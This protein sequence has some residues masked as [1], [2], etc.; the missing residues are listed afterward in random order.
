MAHSPFCWPPEG[1][2]GAWR[3]GPGGSEVSESVRDVG[4]ALGSERPQPGE[5]RQNGARPAWAGPQ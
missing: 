5:T 1:W 4:D 2:V 3:A